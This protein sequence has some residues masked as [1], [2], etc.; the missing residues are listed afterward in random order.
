[1]TV[2]FRSKEGDDYTTKLKNEFS[3]FTVSDY[4]LRD[5]FINEID[6]KKIFLQFQSIKVLDIGGNIKITSQQIQIISYMN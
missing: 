4:K 2:V 3:F 1:M 5:L 6:I